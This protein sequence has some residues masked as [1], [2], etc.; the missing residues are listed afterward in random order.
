MKRI[1][2]AL[3]CAS[4]LWLGT[5]AYAADPLSF[6]IKVGTVNTTMSG[7]T[8]AKAPLGGGDV[9]AS[10]FN[11]GFLVGGYGEY[12]FH[13]MVGGGLTVN[14]SMG[15]M[16]SFSEKSKKENTYTINGKRIN[17]QAG[18]VIYP[19]GMEN[20]EDGILK[21]NVGLNMAFTVG[22]L[23]GQK[24]SEKATSSVAK[25][26]NGFGVGMYGGV[27][28][29]LPMGLLFDLS[30]MYEFTDLFEKDSNFKKTTL[31]VGEKTATQLWNISL[32]TGFNFGVLLED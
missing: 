1:V 23:E 6:G 22:Q 16:G 26:L 29:E 5:N 24:G 3:V 19:M 14:F 21:L 4:S 8:E 11:L 17:I 28:Y 32:G 12:A 20:S 25:D 2:F 15:P 27:G 13:D 18:P 30:T 31:G 7:L 9:E 10:F